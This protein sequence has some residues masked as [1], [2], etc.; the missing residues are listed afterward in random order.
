[1]D[2]TAVGVSDVYARYA[3]VPEDVAAASAAVP[4]VP[5][6]RRVVLFGAGDAIR[7]CEAVRDC[8]AEASGAVIEATAL[9]DPPAWA[10]K[11]SIV[12]VADSA[13]SSSAARS[14]VSRALAKG[15]S[16]A[17]VSAPGSTLDGAR[18]KGLPAIEIQ[19]SN[20]PLGTFGSVFGALSAILDASGTCPMKKELDGAMTPL[21]YFRDRL[22]SGGSGLVGEVSGFVAGCPAAIYAEGTMSSA[23][24][25]WAEAFESVSGVNALSGTQPEFNHNELAGWASGDAVDKSL[26][27]V[28]LRDTG[29]SALARALVDASLA[30]LRS[31]GIRTLSVDV[32]GSSMTEKVLRSAMLGL[33]VAA[34]LGSAEGRSS[35]AP[36][37]DDYPDSLDL[38]ARAVS[39]SLALR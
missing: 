31:L 8:A 18:E 20:V 3:S 35:A 4:E 6:S 17:V 12:V 15:C 19:G 23:S 37:A 28:A 5:E 22:V 25:L 13:G 7:A 9:P 26:V 32:E 24:A 2:A 33:L 21:R 36:S 38:R 27:H 14:A 16:V 1:M 30:D 10:G 39:A 29:A 34:R 11:G